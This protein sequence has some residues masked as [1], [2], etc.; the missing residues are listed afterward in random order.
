[1]VKQNGQRVE[2][3]RDKLRLGFLRALQSARC[4]TTEV[5]DAIERIARRC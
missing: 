1:M 3:D 2:F 4:P 5:D